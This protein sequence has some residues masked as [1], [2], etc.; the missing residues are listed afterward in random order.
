MI[1]VALIMI[2]LA[3]Q[4]ANCPLQGASG[5]SLLL[6]SRDNLSSPVDK[7]TLSGS[8]RGRE[9]TTRL[10]K[11]SDGVRIETGLRG[12]RGQSV[13]LNKTEYPDVDLLAVHVSNSGSRIEV[14]VKY[15]PPND[16]YV[17]DDGRSRVVIWFS[18]G[19][20]PLVMRTGLITENI[21]KGEGR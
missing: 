17:N 3:S 10:F 13:F 1:T 7:V 19:K 14:S 8:T 12:R 5:G 9:F 11:R 15:G 4:T 21:A 2:G 18:E 20:P 16:C 6:S